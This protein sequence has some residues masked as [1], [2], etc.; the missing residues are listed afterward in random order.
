MKKNI[1]FAGFEADGTFSEFHD[2]LYVIEE[3]GSSWLLLGK[4]ITGEVGISQIP[5]FTF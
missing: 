4:S 2:T 3:D 1:S 5:I